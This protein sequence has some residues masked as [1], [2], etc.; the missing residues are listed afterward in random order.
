MLRNRGKIMFMAKA[1]KE[2]IGEPLKKE[3]FEYA[4]Y[5]Y[6]PGWKFKRKREGFDKKELPGFI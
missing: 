3:G 6:F 5:D 4:V 2:I 1:V